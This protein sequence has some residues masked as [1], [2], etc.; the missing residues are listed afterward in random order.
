MPQGISESSCANHPKRK[1]M[2]ICVVCRKVICSECLTRIEG[3]IHCKDCLSGRLEKEKKTAFAG[4]A[5][6]FFAVTLI[7][8]GFLLSVWFF[9]SIGRIAVDFPDSIR[10]GLFDDLLE[11]R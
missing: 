5:G 10:I 6:R 8:L 11:E 7:V 1:G 9:S 2:G 4:I 3:I